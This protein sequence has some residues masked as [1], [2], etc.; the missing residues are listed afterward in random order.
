MINILITGANGFLGREFYYYFSKNKNYNLF[1]TNRQNLDIT[2]EEEVSYFLKNNKIDIVFHCAI[3]GDG[4]RPDA[5]LDLIENL[6]MYRVLYK[7]K[8]YFKLMFNFCS[9]AAFDKTKDIYL[10]KE[11]EIY[12]KF[13]SNYYG[14]AKNIIAKEIQKTNKII[15]LR[16]FGCFGNFETPTRFIKNS[17]QRI[18]RKENIIIEQDRVFDF[19]YIK[20]LCKVIEFYIENINNLNNL[21][22]DVNCVYKEKYTLVD[23]ALLIQK[24]FNKNFNP[25]IYVINSEIGKSYTGDGE[26]L[27]NLD[28]SFIGLKQGIKEVCEYGK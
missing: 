15:N 25:I 28:I 20:D 19:F 13:P 18:K 8:Q 1:L 14:L 17:L 6:E 9:G 21:P 11:E 5:L 3:N 24:Y 16:L 4:K 27:S 7:N 2:N 26:K 12:N 22:K 23:V 10:C